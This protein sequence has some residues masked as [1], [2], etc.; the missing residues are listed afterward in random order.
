MALEMDKLRVLRF[1]EKSSVYEKVSTAVRRASEEPEPDGLWFSLSSGAWIRT[2]DLRV[3][4]H[5]PAFGTIDPQVP[6]FGLA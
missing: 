4:S 2:K 6:T 1:I 5:K 3:M